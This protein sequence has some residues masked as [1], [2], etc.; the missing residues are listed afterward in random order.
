MKRSNIDILKAYV[1]PYISQILSHINKVFPK[2]FVPNPTQ[3]LL[4]AVVVAIFL[5]R[6]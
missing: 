6:R 1:V 5:C 2:D 4:G 3:V